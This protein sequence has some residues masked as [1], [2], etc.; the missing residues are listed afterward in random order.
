MIENDTPQGET[1]A[2][3]NWRR[4]LRRIFWVVAG[5]WWI[6]SAAVLTMNVPP[7]PSRAEFAPQCAP[8]FWQERE[9]RS[10]C[11]IQPRSLSAFFGPAGERERAEARRDWEQ[12]SNVY[13]SC[14]ASADLAAAASIERCQEDRDS[15]EGQRQIDRAHTGAVTLWAGQIAMALAALAAIPFLAGALLLALSRLV[16]WIRDGFIAS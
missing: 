13:A 10:A 1:A 7:A 15:A 14:I 11:G 5:V 4:G 6:G 9:Q 8:S 16:G 12:Q 3:V 2:A